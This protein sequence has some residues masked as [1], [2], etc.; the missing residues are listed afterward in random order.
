MA[1]NSNLADYRFLQEAATRVVNEARGINRVIYDLTSK[2]P[3]TI[4]RE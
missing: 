1:A 2:P 4:E 3:G